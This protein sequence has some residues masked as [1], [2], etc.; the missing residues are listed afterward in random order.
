MKE[1]VT[2]L[3][4]LRDEVLIFPNNDLLVQINSKKT[5]EYVDRDVQ[6]DSTLIKII[7][8]ARIIEKKTGI[9]P[10]CV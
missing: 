2:F 9:N 8:E 5:F 10:T 3:K 7:R 6:D 1:I 4:D